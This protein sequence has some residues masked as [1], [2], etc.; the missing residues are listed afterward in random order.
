MRRAIPDLSGT[1]KLAR[2]VNREAP[3]VLHGWMYHGNLASLFASGC[4]RKKTPVIW[5]IHNLATDLKSLNWS[6]VLAARA[7]GR[8]SMYAAAVTAP[9][10]STMENHIECLG[11]AEADWKVIPNGFDTERFRPLPARE[12]AG[13]RMSLG[14]SD[15]GP[16]VGMLGRYAPVKDHRNMLRA[17]AIVCRTNPDIRFVLAGRNV[18]PTNRELMKT[19]RT[20]GL[21]TQVVLLGE[22]QDVP[23]LMNAFDI[24]ALSSAEECFPMVLGEAMCCGVPCVST[25]VGDAAQIIG[26]TGRIVPKGDAAELAAAILSLIGLGREE[27]RRL[28]NRARIRIANNFSLKMVVSQFEELYRNAADESTPSRSCVQAA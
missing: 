23:R 9:S 19:V 26:D 8:L 20:L 5:S 24:V 4:V 11:Y 27:R 1:I 18:C 17:A 21:E 22:R 14:L 15:G 12:R 6:T 16:I 13:V 2:A 7:G 3:D 28:G 25:N 10:Q